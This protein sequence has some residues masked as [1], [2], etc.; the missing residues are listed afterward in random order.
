MSRG[1]EGYEKLVI[2]FGK[3][4]AKEILGGHMRMSEDNIK[5]DHHQQQ[6]QIVNF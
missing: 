5:S 2:L 1:T 3:L 6:Q 4:Q